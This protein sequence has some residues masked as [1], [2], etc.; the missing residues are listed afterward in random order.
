[1]GCF[2]RGA[3]HYP[4]KIAVK[5][6]E[7]EN[8]EYCLSLNRCVALFAE[9]FPELVAKP[10]APEKR[11]ITRPPTLLDYGTDDEEEEA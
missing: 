6:G 4:G 3:W 7:N 9:N 1:M 11:R 5:P 10:A 2:G 8:C